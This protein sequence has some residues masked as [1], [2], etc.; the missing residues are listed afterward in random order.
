[1]DRNQSKDLCLLY[2]YNW[3]MNALSLFW[4]FSFVEKQNTNTSTSMEYSILL[5]TTDCSNTHSTQSAALIFWLTR[6]I[7]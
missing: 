5:K 3:Q 7:Y 1:M 4:I 2:F 6:G